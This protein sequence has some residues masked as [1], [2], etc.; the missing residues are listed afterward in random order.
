LTIEN[1][2]MLFTDMVGSTA[3]AS[4]VAAHAADELRRAHFSI[5]RQAVAEAGRSVSAG[6]LVH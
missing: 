1:V 4:S 6:V 3:L 2:A 5:L